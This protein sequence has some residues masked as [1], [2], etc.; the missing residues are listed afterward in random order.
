MGNKVT[1]IILSITMLFCLGVVKPGKA[2]ACSCAMV[3]SAEAQVKDEM[4][5]SSAIFAGKVLTVTQP[6]EKEIMSS[7][8]PVEVQFEVSQ[9]WKGDV[10]ARTA[11]YTALSSASCGIEN[12]VE[13]A[14]YIVSAYESEAALHTTICNM[15]KPLDSAAEELKALGDG[16]QPQ[17]IG[18]NVKKERS[19]LPLSADGGE[20]QS[21]AANEAASASTSSN[22]Y[23]LIAALVLLIA[24]A[25]IIWVRR[26]R[27]Q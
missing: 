26:N 10:Q 11:V 12:F 16:K 4:E 17:P 27:K 21:P 1:M 14:E 23:V 5:R 22:I 3:Q 13:G 19:N 6:P 2:F 20:P 24:A 15:T 25:M 9:V 8:D 7:A 18:M